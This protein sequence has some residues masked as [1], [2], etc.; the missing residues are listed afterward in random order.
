MI[1][2]FEKLPPLDHRAPDMKFTYFHHNCW[3]EITSNDKSHAM[4]ISR[5]TKVILKSCLKIGK[6]TPFDCKKWNVKS[7]NFFMVQDFL[8]P[9]I[10]FQGE[11]L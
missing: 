3:K 9:N 5:I 8:N 1:D 6:M 7:L 10:T 4:H 11:K 2:Q